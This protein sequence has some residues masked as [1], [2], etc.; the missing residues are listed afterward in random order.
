ML[1]H[2]L[3][4]EQDFLLSPSFCSKYNFFSNFRFAIFFLKTNYKKV[5]GLK[6]RI[7][8][9]FVAA[10]FIFQRTEFSANLQQVF[11][12]KNYSFILQQKK[13]GRLQLL[14]TTYNIMVVVVV[15]T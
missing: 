4:I 12:E 8:Q 6:S 13:I 15:G 11:F 2:K 3:F 10:S 9:I 1:E 7:N 5:T 14:Y